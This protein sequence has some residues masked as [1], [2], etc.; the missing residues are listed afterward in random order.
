[1]EK[2]LVHADAVAG[3]APRGRTA[4]QDHRLARELVESKKDQEEH[5]VVVRCVLEALARHC[6]TLAAPEAPGLLRTDGIQHLHTPIQGRL[7]EPSKT[8][9]LDLVADLH[10]TPAVGGA[11]RQHALDWLRGHE[12]LDRGWY[13]GPLGWVTPEGEGEFTVALRSMLL[14]GCRAT[15][16]AGAGIVAGSDPE[17]EL[18]ETRLKLR[19]GLDALLEI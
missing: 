7:R 11:P 6:S 4:G 1:M 8:T 17:A 5:A 15:L 18:A 2:G 3:S 10:P 12:G 9:V 13:A 16:F 14:H 19:A